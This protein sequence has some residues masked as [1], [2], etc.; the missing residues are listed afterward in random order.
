[1]STEDIVLA[2]QQGSLPLPIAEKYLK[3]YV[4]DIDWLS[5]I[6]TL[7]KNSSFKFKDDNLA[8]DHVKK[9]IACTIL[10]PA[11]EKTQI[12]DPPSNLLFW[13]QTW[14]QFNEHDW[15]AM[16]LGVFQE[17]INITS[18]RNQLLKIGI[19]DPI[20]VNPMSRQA[21]NWIYEKV[22]SDIKSH[23]IN[24]VPDDI[25]NKIINLVRTYGGAIICNIFL[26]H[27]LNIDK[28]LNWRS[29]YFFE[30]QI[31]KVYS[32]DQMMKIKSTELTKTNS[33]YIKKIGAQQ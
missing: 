23:G 30:K 21:F 26:K 6:S 9:A 19:I 32:I 33:K 7:W 15:F 14:Q 2:V 18:S 29:G 13:S 5:H 28:V 8:K 20:D 27:K 24:T 1:M 31:Y 12:P 22:E 3:L 16:L 25:K 17:D 4:A 11:V 10:L